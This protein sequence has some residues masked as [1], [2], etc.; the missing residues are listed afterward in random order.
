MQGCKE[1][2]ARSSQNK[3]HAESGGTGHAEMRE[4]LTECGI[5]ALGSACA[6]HGVTQ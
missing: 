1:S 2:P 6:L 3:Q 4:C 5:P